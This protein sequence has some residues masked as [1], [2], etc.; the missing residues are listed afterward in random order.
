MRPH[1]DII[2]DYRT[3]CVGIFFSERSKVMYSD[4][5][6]HKLLANIEERDKEIASLE[7]AVIILNTQRNDEEERTKVAVK[8]L[9]S[10]LHPEEFGWAVSQE[11]RKE[12]KQTLI[13]LGEFY[14]RDE[15]KS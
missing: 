15:I 14:E 6:T 13:N 7:E 12:V 4:W 3:C 8:F 2:T 11:V 5:S 9:R 1:Y 10:L